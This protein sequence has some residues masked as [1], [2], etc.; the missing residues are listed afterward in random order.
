M[1]MTL[2]AFIS[3]AVMA[4]E[5]A[6]AMEINAQK[7]KPIA[8]FEK[9]KRFSDRQKSFAT[10]YIDMALL[11]DAAHAKSDF[12]LLANDKEQKIKVAESGELQIPA[13][14]DV[15]SDPNATLMMPSDKYKDGIDVNYRIKIKL[16]LNESIDKKT[17]VQV[18]KQYEMATKSMFGWASFAVP[19]LDCLALVYS[20]RYI[21]KDVAMLDPALVSQKTIKANH[22]SMIFVDFSKPVQSLKILE[23]PMWIFGCKYSRWKTDWE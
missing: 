8:S 22:N 13:I 4:D 19:Q 12:V 20:K 1:L 9:A 6:A 14:G 18:V 16:P 15:L 23:Q 11:V 7:L 3:G 2:S 5:L 21:D 10:E 17:M